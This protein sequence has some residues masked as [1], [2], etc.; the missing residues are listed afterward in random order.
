MNEIIMQYYGILAKMVA[1]LSD[2]SYYCAYLARNVCFWKSA[3][4]RIPQ[5]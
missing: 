2:L 5:I 4:C 1:C 3:F